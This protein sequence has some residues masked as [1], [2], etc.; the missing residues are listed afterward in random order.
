MSELVAVRVRDCECPDTPHEEGDVVYVAPTLPLAGGLQA[1]SD[2]A[3]ALAA[4]IATAG[5]MP[6]GGYSEAAKE[7]MAVYMVEQLRQKWLVTYV[8]YG[9][10]DWNLIGESGPLPF[11]V[12]AL[13]ADYSL[14]RLVADK[15]DE[16][17]GETVA[18]PLLQR[19]PKPSQPGRTP[20]KTSAKTSTQRRNGSSSPP[21]G[22]AASKR[23]TA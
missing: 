13:V 10:K 9:A 21:N 5:P 16:L 8:R 22:P 23:L 17:Y 2:R 12:E 20:R 18:L 3:A 4:A 1:E 11:S 6:Q 19:Q 15:C 14:A 7:S